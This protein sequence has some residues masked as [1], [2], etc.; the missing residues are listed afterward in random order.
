MPWWLR[1]SGGI[2]LC[3]RNLNSG[4]S[5]QLHSMAD[6]YL[7]K[8]LY[9]HWEAQ[10][11]PE[12]AWTLSRREN[13]SSHL[14][15]RRQKES[16]TQEGYNNTTNINP[17]SGSK[18]VVFTWTVEQLAELR[19]RCRLLFQPVLVR[20]S[21]FCKLTHV[22][23]FCTSQANVKKPGLFNSFHWIV[24][25]CR[26]RY[27]NFWTW[28]PLQYFPTYLYTDLF[29]VPQSLLPN[30]DTT[31]SSSLNF[32]THKVIILHPPEERRCVSVITD[33]DHYVIILKLVDSI[34][35]LFSLL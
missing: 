6:L 7:W 14:P 35:I 8:D 1:G 4:W 29:C 13:I 12:S 28:T 25:Q 32:S 2:A 20:S 5:G 18:F 10:R 17:Y 26:S 16:L 34:F 27:G 23:S 19:P 11:N 21:D 22:S 15:R 24:P 30:S 33:A 9:N 31:V 3:I